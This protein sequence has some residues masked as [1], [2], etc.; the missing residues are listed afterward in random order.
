MSRGKNQKLKLLYLRDILLKKTDETHTLSLQQIMG[1][2]ALYGVEAER[3]S[4]YDDLEQLQQYGLDIIH[5]RDGKK[6]GYYVG[7]KIFDLAELKILVDAV[8]SS[9]FITEKKT[10]ELIHKLEGFLSEYEARQLHRFV[11]VADRAKTQNERIFYEVDVIHMA[12]NENKQ[13]TFQY[14]QWNEEKE[15]VPKRGGAW[16]QVSPW[17]LCWGDENYYLVAYD[18]KNEDIR[19]YRVDKM[20]HTQIVDLTRKGEAVLEG[21]DM[22]KYA[23]KM[24]GMFG[25]EEVRIV[26]ACTPSFVGIFLDRFGKNI[27][28][29]SMQDGRLRVVIHVALSDA[30]LAWIIGLGK[31]VEIIQPV[32][33]RRRMEEIGTHLKNVYEKE[34]GR[35]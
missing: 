24:F 8:Q 33:V 27:Q 5:Q 4:L 10:R 22:A 16:Y 21:L 23:K 2:L 12:L 20:L 13:I 9:K 19:H 7:E 26:L 15:L 34:P 25:G 29:Q 3:K 35:D 30:F 28:V 11:F 32:H 14:C 6:H 17:A 31:D 18:E 1:Q